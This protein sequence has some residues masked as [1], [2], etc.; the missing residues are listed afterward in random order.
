M[1]DRIQK[2]ARQGVGVIIS[3]DNLKHLFSITDRILVLYEGRLSAER[4]TAD[5]TQRDIV[6]LIVGTTNR[7]QVTPIIWALESYQAARAPD[8]RALP[9]AGRAA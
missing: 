6:E 8:R 9:H 1:L 4:R 2:L 5:C 3:S 7:E